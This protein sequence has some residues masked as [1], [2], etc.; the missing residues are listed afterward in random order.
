MDKLLD[1]FQ[2]QVLSLSKN[3]D[4]PSAASLLDAFHKFIVLVAAG[5]SDDENEKMLRL[6]ALQ[7]PEGE[8]IEPLEPI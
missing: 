8:E 6:L 3:M 4:S 5:E 1:C 7:T 2:F